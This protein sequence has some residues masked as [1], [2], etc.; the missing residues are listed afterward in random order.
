MKK[1]KSLE[2]SLIALKV[3]EFRLILECNGTSKKLKE[4]KK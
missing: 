2:D 4:R 3:N 1:T